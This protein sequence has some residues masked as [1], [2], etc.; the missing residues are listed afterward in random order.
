[1]LGNWAK[2]F[3]FA[4]S[5]VLHA[6]KSQASMQVHIVIALSVLGMAVY[7]Q[8]S[9]IEFAI[10]FLCIG[11][12]L[13]AEIFNTAIESVV[14]LVS[15]E[16]VELARIAKDAAAGAVLV[17]SVAAAFVGLIIMG[18][19]LLNELSHLWITRQ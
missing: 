5:G 17:L 18:P 3:G 6:V 9:R 2:K 4:V 8:L 11:T 10:L 19:P 16:R 14:D 15:P 12:V 13:A 7:L 1:M